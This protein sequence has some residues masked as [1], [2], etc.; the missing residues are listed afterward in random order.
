MFSSSILLATSF[1]LGS[2]ASASE[3]KTNS[4]QAVV[5]N[6]RILTE[7]Y[8]P[9]NYQKDDGKVDGLSTR[10]VFAILRQLQS[11]NNS[12]GFKFGEIEVLPWKRAYEIAQNEPN[13]LIYSL[14]R[15]EPREDLFWWV[16]KIYE[17][18]SV[19]VTLDTKKDQLGDMNSLDKFKNV[20]NGVLRGGAAAE[21]LISN[22]FVDGKNI[23]SSTKYDIALQ[24][25]Y[26]DRDV[27]T[28]YA[29]L[30]TVLMLCKR[31]G[32]DHKR[33]T[34]LYC[35]PERAPEVS[36]IGINKKH[37]SDELAKLLQKA[38]DSVI[39]SGEFEAIVKTF[40]EELAN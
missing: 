9:R 12:S 13:V 32:L 27:D 10:I 34:T 30:D 37:N 5:Q 21:F 15:T 19:F 26:G 31:L 33:I 14:N 1:F 6:V 25:L 35:P 22:G 7:D 2:V 29:P 23:D 36:Y 24:K 18:K 39:A 3:G 17:T 11:D 38:L 40:N 8:P 28:V 20:R 16:G 4:A